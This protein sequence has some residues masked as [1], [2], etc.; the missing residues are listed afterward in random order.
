M[1]RNTNTSGYNFYR[2]AIRKLA[3]IMMLVTAIT[4]VFEVQIPYAAV[5]GDSGKVVESRELPDAQAVSVYGTYKG[6]NAKR[7]PIITYHR[8]VSDKQKKKGVARGSSLYISQSNFRKQMRWLSKHGYRSISCQ[9]FRLWYEGKIKLPKKS[10]L[11]TFDDSRECIATYA[12]PVLKEFGMKGT[13]FTIGHG[14]INSNKSSIKLKDMAALQE[15]YPDVEFQSHTY[16]LHKHFSKKGVYARVQKDAAKQ[17]KYFGFDYI[18]YPYGYS[19]KAM[20]N[21]YRDSGIK[22]GFA[23]GDNGYATRKQGRFQIK[24]IKVYGNGSMSQFRRWF[25]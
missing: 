9:E 23:Y 2:R 17:A 14:V 10:V 20:R 22:M 25:K 8:V 4:M 18:A 1:T 16:S 3:V 13:V 21:A 5:T 15:N 11:I 19:T 24:R 7:I 12:F 6:K